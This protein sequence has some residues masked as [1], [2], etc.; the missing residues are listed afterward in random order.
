MDFPKFYVT[1][2]L[3]GEEA[4]YNPFWHATLLLSRQDS[5]RAPIIVENAFGFYSEPSTT[6]NPVVRGIKSMLGLSMDLQNG[7]G[8]LEQEKI[9]YLEGNGLFGINFE[10]TKE[11]F[12]RLKILQKERMKA[13][14]AVIAELDAILRSEGKTPNGQTR[15]VKEKELAEHEGREPRL[16]PFHIDARVTHHGL[17]TTTSY[18]CK[19]DALHLL[20]EAGIISDETAEQMRGD[21]TRHAF[22]R[23]GKIPVL[24]LRFISTGEPTRVE[25]KSKHQVFYNRIWN[26]EG[27]GAQLLWATPLITTQQLNKAL[28][29]SYLALHACIKNLLTRAQYIELALRRKLEGSHLDPAYRQQ[30][31]KQLQQ[32]QAIYTDFGVAHKDFN[33]LTK[34]VSDAEVTLN[35]AEMSLTPERVNYSF[36]FRAAQ[37]VSMQYAA[38]GLLVLIAA[39]GLIACPVTMAAGAAI[40]G[41]AALATSHQFHRF[42]RNNTGFLAMRADYLRAYPNPS[43]DAAD[44]LS[45]LH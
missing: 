4:G 43:S 3:M 7:H 29:A 11:Q 10:V 12:E 24:P 42:F 28:Q 8:H 16:K 35:V 22:P 9:R 38:L 44:G 1:Y 36:F 26:E 39:A 21:A 13:E 14:Q 2:G 45:T 27:E 34:K 33:L 40:V 30:L 15:F 17:D 31:V 32:V 41:V 37:D 6:T 19:N 18:S 20:K 23:F 25:S 5:E